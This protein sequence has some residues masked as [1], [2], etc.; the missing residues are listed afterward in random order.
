MFRPPFSRTVGNVTGDIAPPWSVRR[1]DLAVAGGTALA[2]LLLTVIATEEDSTPVDVRAF[3]LSG[4]VGVVLLWRRRY[5]IGVLVASLVLVV[6]YHSLGY[7]ALGNLPLTAALM[8]ATYYRTAAPA[9]AVASISIAGTFAWFLIGES[10][11]L[12]ESINF[13][14]QESAILAAV[15]LAG[16]VLRS[17]RQLDEQSR[18]RLR[19]ARA[20]QEARASK[21]MTEE[22]MQIAREI[23][24]VVA[25]T[26][27]VI[28][29]QAKVAMDT[30]SSSPGEAEQAL[31]I[32]DRSTRDATAELRATVGVLRSNPSL[33]PAPRLDQLQSLVESLSAG[34]DLSVELETS[35]DSRQ[36]S[37][38]VELVAYRVVQEALTNVVRHANAANALVEVDFGKSELTVSVA[39]DGTGGEAT[40]GHG[41][42][43]MRERV[44]AAGGSFSIGPSRLGG[45][46]VL[47]RLP[48]E[49]QR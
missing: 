37:G 19:L 12:A 9:V 7:P 25:H 31:K 46:S 2:L 39:D 1:T 33:S 29:V 22:R 14:I 23:H 18:E 20:D 13:V 40:T 48:I 26:V 21:R 15:I 28:G 32:I 36:L 34:G 44:E 42:A 47:A 45:V 35:G 38:L 24:D 43:G 10:R 49:E 30:L 4:L 11:D 41:I 8:S 16:S 17:R 5:P 27:A 3:V 6:A